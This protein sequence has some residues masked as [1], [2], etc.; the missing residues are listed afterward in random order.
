MA[1]PLYTRPATWDDVVDLAVRLHRHGVRYVLVGGYALA[2]H[3]FTRMTIDIDIA[4]APDSDNSR[5]WVAALSEL[6]DA[7]AREL[8]GED[9]PFR[10]DLLHALRINDE[11]TIDV[12]PSVAGIDFETLARHAVTL[13]VDGQPI[14]VLDL[15]GLL[16]TKS[17]DRAKDRAD[18]ELLRAALEARK[19]RGS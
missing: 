16:M 19:S 17:G 4:V 9:D 13:E 10:G 15:D 1:E 7:A 6:P 14:R 12:M 8:V 2:A 11:I 18:A 5:R 3:G